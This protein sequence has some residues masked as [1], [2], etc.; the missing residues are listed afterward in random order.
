MFPDPMVDT[1]LFDIEQR[2]RHA[3]AERLAGSCSRTPAGPVRPL[4]L[5]LGSGLLRVA[6]LLLGDDSPVY[7]TP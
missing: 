3:S 7:A 4:R 1:Q 5:A 2:R 6:V